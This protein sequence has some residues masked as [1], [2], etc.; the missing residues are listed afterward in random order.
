MKQN[1]KRATKHSIYSYIRVILSVVLTAVFTIN[2][3]AA[4][5]RDINYHML[6]SAKWSHMSLSSAG[7]PQCNINL[8]VSQ[9]SGGW[10]QTQVYAKAISNWNTY[11]RSRIYITQSSF[12]DSNVDLITYKGDEWAYDVGTKAFTI[13]Y[14]TNG[15]VWS[16]GELSN[17][18]PATAFGNRIDY[19]SVIF[20]LDY[21]DGG[22]SSTVTADKALMNLRKTMTHEIGHCVNLAHPYST[23]VHC[24]MASGWNLSWSD[25]DEPMDYD[26]DAMENIYSQV[27]S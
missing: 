26:G 27:Y 22:L 10:A 13:L 3:S 7:T 2:V 21:D 12:S 25:Y 20:N 24:V 15:S 16:G 5:S 11:S 19:S 18:D 4:N 23:A 17:D 8:S 14:S 9:L 6:N 1:I